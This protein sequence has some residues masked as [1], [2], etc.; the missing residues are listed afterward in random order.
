M[1]EARTNDLIHSN[2]PYLLKHAHNPVF[3]SEWGEGAFERARREDKPVFLSVGYSSCH[4]CH[5][6]MEESF[7]DEEVASILNRDFVPVKVDREERP[8]VDA[9]YMRACQ[10]MTGSGG[11]PLTALLTP[12]QAPFFTGT[13]F[14]KRSI[15]G[16]AGLIE[17]LTAA[18]AAWKG[19]RKGLTE[20]GRALDGYLRSEG[21]AGE[22]DVPAEARLPERAFE[23]LRRAFDPAWGGFGSAPK[24]PTPSTLVFLMRYYA[25]AG[26]PEALTMVEKTLHHMAEGGVFDHLGGGFCRYSTDRKWLIPHFEK[27]L[28]DNALLLYAYAQAYK[29][30][31]REAWREVAGSIVSYLSR[32]MRAPGGGFYAAQDAD[33]E[34]REG[35]FYALTPGE[36]ERVL[37][38]E[39][40]RRFAHAF[41]IDEDGNFEGASVPNRI[42]RPDPLDGELRGAAERM[43]AYRRARRLLPTDDKIMTEWNALTIGAL[44]L[45]ARA[46]ERADML[47]LAIGAQ[48]FLSEQLQRPDGLRAY[49]REGRAA[50]PAHLSDYAAFAW[51][52]LELY[53][54]TLN[55]A[56]LAQ[57]R[58]LCDGMLERFYDPARGDFFL[59]EAGG[60]LVYR[61]KEHM[62]GA[63]VS[64]N[65]LAAEVFLRLHAIT[66]EAKWRDLLGSLLQALSAEAAEYP[67]GYCH[68]LT[69]ILRARHTMLRVGCAS[70][71]S[72][73][74]EGAVR[75]AGGMYLKNAVLALDAP[76]PG[77]PGPAFQLC[78]GETCA[79]PI[80]DDRALA[81]ALEA[82]AVT[83]CAAL[84]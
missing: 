27:M 2:S 45:A 10:A 83:A 59:G 30:R 36:C 58:T 71:D 23:Q 76:E 82:R 72:A 16:R 34:G 37:G 81:D 61:A 75:L 5:V 21:K 66:G 68:A 46:F 17:I 11:W 32:D 18:S 64:G 9:V 77:A 47:A 73:R 19:D 38:R 80:G 20:S 8:D 29:I 53:E 6:M 31:R 42:G 54:A 70:G 13:Y 26:A 35:A 3:W 74:L 14:P 60:D 52:D 1:S 56:Y 63:T 84:N 78:E 57:A 50:G 49:W 28:Y 67:A 24:F 39:M 15:R 33:S 44:A 51:A 69:V 22:A 79:A 43:A 41:G 65:A 4:W 62:D 12:D 55:P 25:L 48:R 40:G 7:E